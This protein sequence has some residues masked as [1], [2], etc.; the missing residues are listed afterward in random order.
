MG[1]LRFIRKMRN[2]GVLL[3]VIGKLRL[4][5]M[6]N[7][8]RLHAYHSELLLLF[9]HRAIASLVVRKD[10]SDCKHSS[11]VICSSRYFRFISRGDRQMLYITVQ[12]MCSG[13]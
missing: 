2:C 10:L 3:A 6:V 11:Y 1:Y 8:T 5:G 7:T 9:V 12:H 4:I 13:M